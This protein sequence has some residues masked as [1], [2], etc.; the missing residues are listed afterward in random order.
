MF[1]RDIRRN[2]DGKQHTALGE[3]VGVAGSE[4]ANRAEFRLDRQWF[5]RSAMSELLEVDSAVAEKDRLHRCLDRLLATRNP[6]R[7]SSCSC[8]GSA[9]LNPRNRLRRLKDR[10]TEL[11]AEALVACPC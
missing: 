7:I 3:S 10:S 4:L 6:S 11:P 8:T 9:F 5:D 2:K 1:L